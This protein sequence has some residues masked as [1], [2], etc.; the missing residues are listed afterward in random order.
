MKLTNDTLKIVFTYLSTILLL[1]FGFYALVIY[2][3]VL[4]D[5]V[6]GAIIGFMGSAIAFMYGDQVATRTAKQSEAA[7]ASGAL[8]AQIPYPGSTQT[9]LPLDPV[10]GGSTLGRDG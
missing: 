4:D 5:L 9:G 6:K 1:S 10:T 8:Q 7:S 2:P 3:F